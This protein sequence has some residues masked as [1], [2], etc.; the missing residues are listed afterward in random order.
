MRLSNLQ[1]YLFEPPDQPLRLSNCII[2]HQ[3]DP[4]RAIVWVEPEADEQSVCVE[5]TKPYTY[6]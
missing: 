3:G 1:Q 6:L 2:M 4:D 5:V